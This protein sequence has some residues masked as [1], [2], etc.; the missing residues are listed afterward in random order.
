MVGNLYV[1]F[2]GNTEKI[3]QAIDYIKQTG[4]RIE[5]ISHD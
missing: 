4:T 1:E 5:V 2:Y 3:K